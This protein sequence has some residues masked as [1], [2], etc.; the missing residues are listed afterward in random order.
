MTPRKT[1]GRRYSV[2]AAALAVALTAASALAVPA[3]VI[4]I[5]DTSASMSE[6]LDA[7]EPEGPTKLERAKAIATE[8]I[9]AADRQGHRVSLMR[10][11]Q[12]QTIVATGEGE[13]VLTGEHPHECIEMVD[14]V[15]PHAIDAHGDARKWLDGV[16]DVTNPELAAIG[17]SPLYGSVRVAL[18]Y[19]RAMRQLQPAVHCVNAAIFVVTDGKD[20]CATG[21]ELLNALSELKAQGAGEDIQA[22]AVSATVGTEAVEQIADVGHDDAESTRAYSFDE[23]SQL[24]DIA[25]A[26]VGRIA[27]AAC[28]VSGVPREALSNSPEVDL[29]GAESA[30][31]DDPEEDASSGKSGGCNASHRS[32]APWAIAWGLL[33]ALA[34]R[35]RGA[36]RVMLAAIVALV[37]SIG[38]SDDKSAASGGPEDEEDAVVGEADLIVVPPEDTLAE[39]LAELDVQIAAAQTAL[40]D[41]LA[42]ITNAE[43]AFATITGDK[44]EGCKA[45]LNAVS[46]E[47]YR[48]AQ[49]GAQG[50]WATRR[51]SNLDQAVLL[52]SCLDFHG[53][54]STMRHCEMS[55]E[56][57]DALRAAATLPVEP[58]YS[59]AVAV[60]QAP[61]EEAVEGLGATDYARIFGEASADLF[62]RDIDKTVDDDI[63]KLM[64][65]LTVDAASAT[66]HANKWLADATEEHYVLDIGA[67]DEEGERFVPILESEE[68]LFCSAQPFNWRDQ[69][70]DGYFELLVQYAEIYE[71]AGGKLLTPTPVLEHTWKTAD[72]WDEPVVISI[73]EEGVA[74]PELG[75]PPEAQKGCFQAHVSGI[76][77]EVEP[78]PTFFLAGPAAGECTG[79]LALEPGPGIV[80]VRVILR[81]GVRYGTSAGNAQYDYHERVLI[82]R[83]GYADSVTTAIATGP[84]YTLDAMRAM[85]PLRAE[86]NFG[87]GRAT[88][89]HHYAE[90]MR[91]VV[92]SRDHYAYELERLYGVTDDTP[93]P[94]RP[95]PPLHS[96]TFAW[97]GDRVP[98]LLSDD[99]FVITTL[100]WRT[101]AMTRRGYG[102]I[103]DGPMTQGLGFKAQTIFDIIEAIDVVIGPDN[104]AEA[105]DHT[106]R[107]EANVGLGALMTEAERLAVSAYGNTLTVINAGDMFR[108]GGGEWAVW[109]STPETQSVLFPMAV[110]DAASAPYNAYTT[111]IVS[112]TDVAA[113]DGSTYMAWWRIDERT[114]HA[115]GELRY[116]G[117]FYGGGVASAIG[118]FAHCLAFQAVQALTCHA[119][120]IPNVSCCKLQVLASLMAAQVPFGGEM[121]MGLQGAGIVPAYGE[122]PEA[123]EKIRDAILSSAEI[124][125]QAQSLTQGVDPG[126]NPLAAALTIITTAKEAYD[127]TQTL[128][129]PPPCMSYVVDNETVVGGGCPDKD[130]EDQEEG[131]EGDEGN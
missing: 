110:R 90:M 87:G 54:E 94:A 52:Q 125:V 108:H 27:P 28:V 85:L 20:T 13:K 5:V 17:G 131:G 10:F 19:I 61:F 36:G 76:G 74:A 21:S 124:L 9:E 8:L 51:C 55:P 49:R 57:E 86:L 120:V 2:A 44:V 82:D 62:Q 116:D 118:N 78:G 53:V 102:P 113:A 16:S 42:E 130:P 109:N 50:C 128:Q 59:E 72:Q 111:L 56:A 91:Y 114:G 69:A 84:Q 89:A 97:Y 106:T 70:S 103:D 30:S 43:A 129:K 35:R 112:P 81:T 64:P 32:A 77:D 22:Y 93:P 126:E 75:L 96:A 33:I 121:L 115:L 122:P 71:G 41:H 92:G 1:L 107:L 98:R 23:A 39:A 6:P 38:C 104:G 18:R 119:Q 127:A 105:A 123:T 29:P 88:Q 65:M 3:N 58:D 79:P 80:L 99:A 26:L 117:T 37:A 15:V 46:F 14:V 60:V 68:G 12:L 11:R 31:V 4:V 67:E 40:D 45:L 73:A 48:G 100:P 101:V 25:N 63:A 83:W 66:L 47:P 34:R 7:A 24:V 95:T